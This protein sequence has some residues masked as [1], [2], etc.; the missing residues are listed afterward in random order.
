MKTFKHLREQIQSV[1]GGV[2]ENAEQMNELKTGTLIRYHTKAGQSGLKAGIEAA[3]KQDMDDNA[4]AVPF[5]KKR[6]Q[7]MKGQMQAMSKIQARHRTG[8]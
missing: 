5:Q 8:K 7:R 1:T 3:R 4:G 6:D 2:A